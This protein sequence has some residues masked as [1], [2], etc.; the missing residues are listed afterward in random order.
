MKITI[1]PHIGL[2]LF[3]LTSFPAVASNWQLVADDEKMRVEIDVATLARNGSNGNTVKAWERETYRQPGQAKPGDFYFKSA[4]S[5][6]QHHCTER[7]TR[8][9]F[10]AFFAAD[11]SEIK[12]INSDTD[13]DK[14]DFLVPDSLEERKLIFACTRK[15]GAK[16]TA[17]P[18]PAKAE[19]PIASTEQTP[20]KPTEK[21]I[22][23]SPT[24]KIPANGK[25]EK[26]TGIKPAAAAQPSAAPPVK[27]P[28]GK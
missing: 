25:P 19:P 20:V 15:P 14:V 5:L 23:P 24:A 17:K 9:L 7:T 27:T 4:K 28:M 8:Y 10:R 1:A 3:L 26:A 6:A 13:L 11:G 22:K 2:L 16:K 21:N 12:V 18:A